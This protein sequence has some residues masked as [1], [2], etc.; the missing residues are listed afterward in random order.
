MFRCYVGDMYTNRPQRCTNSQQPTFK[1][2]SFEEDQ[3]LAFVGGLDMCYGR[4]DTSSHLITDND[5]LRYPGIDYNN[6]RIRDLTN[7]RDFWVDGVDRNQPRLPWHDVAVRFEG[8][9]VQ[10]VCL[11]FIE[12]W[13]YASFQT[14]Y[15]D[16]YVLILDK[17]RPK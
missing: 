12:Y 5:P 16:R 6:C 4:Y 1:L 15:E 7:V 9:V 10:D 13:N 14:H 17:D 2:P 11:H 3:R 8:E